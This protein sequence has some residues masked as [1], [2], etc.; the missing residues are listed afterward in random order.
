[1]SMNSPKTC[2]QCGAPLIEGAAIGLCPRCVMA[3]NLKPE[4]VFTGELAAASAPLTPQ[5]LAEFKKA[6]LPVYTE[7]EPKIGPALVKEFQ[8]AVQSAK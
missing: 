5:E 7:W 1:M 2:P 4:T 3:L 6:T 8:D